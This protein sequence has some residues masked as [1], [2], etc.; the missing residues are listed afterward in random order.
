MAGS[1]ERPTFVES[2]P[3]PPQRGG[4]IWRHQ[5]NDY[6]HPRHRHDPLEL[7]V[8]V[9]G[10]GHYEVDGF[11]HVLTPGSV[12]W[13]HPDQDHELRERSEDFEMWIVALDPAL[14]SHWGDSAAISSLLARTPQD[15]PCK[16]LPWNDIHWVHR[17]FE[18]LTQTGS[19]EVLRAGL[20]YCTLGLWET[21]TATAGAASTV[22]SSIE[23]AMRWL[24][25]DP[26]IAT[27]ELAERLDLSPQWLARRFRS[28]VGV[29]LSV[30]QNE[31]RV[32]RFAEFIL[33]PDVTCLEACYRAGFGSYAQCHR[34]FTKHV[35]C[36][37]R[38]F[39]VR[40]AVKR[41]GT[42]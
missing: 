22:S 40:N 21:F 4:C 8:T 2:L 7:N 32:E 12:L 6:D 14:I 10:R 3:I 24:R 36:S 20:A 39:I 13:I 31:L 35:G 1:I 33:Q 28:E 23:A 25:Q 11:H 17:E 42:A 15:E 34:L 27:E 26:S 9:R 29:S 5:G 18:R 16:R 19:T 38:D 41:T 30:Y 37:P